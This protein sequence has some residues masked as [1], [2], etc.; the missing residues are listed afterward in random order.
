MRTHFDPKTIDPGTY[1]TLLT[2]SVVPRPIAWVSTMSADGVPNLAPYSFYSVSSSAP[3]VVQFTSVGRKDSLRNIEETGEF[4]I[5]L[6]TESLFEQINQT[7][8][9]YD[10]SVS[11]YTA[12]D[13]ESEP[14]ETVRPFR[15]AASPVSIEATLHQVIEVGN[16]FVVMGAVSLITV[17]SECL[18]EDGLPD[19][20]AIAPLSRL[21]RDQWG[22]PPE[23][24]RIERPHTP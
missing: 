1:Y 7:S 8:A 3:P 19:F 24:R 16:S 18:S 9:N 11:E 10:S 13:L 17:R 12:V 14:S 4:V 23:V 6:A 5:N 2:A 22:L 15:V 21:G 20:A